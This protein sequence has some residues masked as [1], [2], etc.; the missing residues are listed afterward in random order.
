MAAELI[1]AAIGDG[2]IA[3][4]EAA[5]GGQIASESSGPVS[6]PGKMKIAGV[7]RDTF[8]STIGDKVIVHTADLGVIEQMDMSI[9]VPAAAEGKAASMWCYCACTVRMINGEAI[10]FPANYGQIKAII[11]RAGDAAMNYLMV[12]YGEK[13]QGLVEEAKNA[14]STLGSDSP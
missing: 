5:A 7:L 1:A 9:A 13:M 11:Q 4:A 10:G 14:Q 8:T 3:Q 2:A 6:V 12:R